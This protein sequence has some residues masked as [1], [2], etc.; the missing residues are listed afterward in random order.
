MKYKPGTKIKRPRVGGA[1]S[2]LYLGTRRQLL[3]LSSKALQPPDDL[4]MRSCLSSRTPEKCI[5]RKVLKSI[6]Y[7][8]GFG[9]CVSIPAPCKRCIARSHASIFMKIATHWKQKSYDLL[10]L[11]NNL[12]SWERTSMKVRAE[13]YLADFPAAF[14]AVPS[15][16]AMIPRMSSS[17][18][19]V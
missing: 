1:A 3:T 9:V 16:A 10:S 19:I 11:E 18:R 2:L 5:D 6:L 8:A 4:N 14:V 12:A 13:I 15:P 7:C 17:L